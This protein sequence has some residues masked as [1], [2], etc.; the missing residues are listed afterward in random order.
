MDSHLTVFPAAHLQGSR[1]GS[2]AGMQE[3]NCVWGLGLGT[4]FN[5]S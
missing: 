3:E 1:L 2:G 4:N 5:I